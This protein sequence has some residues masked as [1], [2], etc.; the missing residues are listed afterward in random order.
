MSIQRWPKKHIIYPN[1]AVALEFEEMTVSFVLMTLKAQLELVTEV[2]SLRIMIHD[3]TEAGISPLN[4]TGAYHSSSE[5]CIDIVQT[6]SCRY[7]GCTGTFHVT[8]SQRSDFSSST[9]EKLL[10]ICTVGS[11]GDRY[12]GL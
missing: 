1:L 5:S 2:L 10:H 9:D 7:R 8:A 12:H 11:A 4:I 3:R 6:V